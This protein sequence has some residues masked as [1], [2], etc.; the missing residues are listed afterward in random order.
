MSNGIT[1]RDF[2]DGVACSVIAGSGLLPRAGRAGTEVD[3]PPGVTG[4]R[5]SR[6]ADLAVGHALR[7]GA[8]FNIDD[9]P[10]SEEVDFVV[11][12]AGIGGL[13]SAYFLRKARPAASVLILDNH[14]EFGGHARRNEFQVDG[15]LLIGYGGSESI[16]S[17]KSYWSPTA[18][19]LL[20]D[21]G[22]RLDRFEKAIDTP[23]YP[24]LG[25]STGV[26]FPRET[27]GKDTLVTGDPQ[28]SLPTDIPAELHHG[29]PIAQFAANCPLSDTARQDLVRLHTDTSDVMPGMD[30]S[31][32]IDTLYSISYTEF[33]ER[34][35]NMD[36][37][38]VHL[39]NFRPID[40][41][42][43]PGRLVPALYMAGSGYP[44]FQG[45]GLPASKDLAA[46][47]EPYIYHFPDGNASIARLLVRR[48][49]PRV[50]PG[51]SMEDIVTAKFDYA[52]LDRKRSPV[53]LRL[54]STVV[55]LRNAKGGAD[56]LYSRTGAVRRIRCKKAIYAGFYAMMPYLCPDV[57]APQRSA[58][59]QGV[60]SPLVYITVA[61][62]NW[63][64]W[65][66][67]GVHLINNPTGFYSIAK[68]D[69][70]V[71]LG[72]YRFAK[73]PDEPILIH[74]SNTPHAPQPLADRRAEVRA[75]RQVLYTRPFSEFETA[76][77]DEL[78]RML[79]S[80]GF[81]ADRDIAAITINR[82]GHGYAYD[83]NPLTDPDAPE[84][85]PTVAR[86]AIGNIS[87]SG[88]DAAWTAY[89]H[90]AIDEAHRAAT[91]VLT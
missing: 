87:V 56:V 55:Q 66:N 28:R 25:L 12:G 6:D 61:V 8:K 39:F 11:V 35:W 18:L 15:R 16:Q 71:S 3:Y 41:Y 68:L 78:T 63:R 65:M 81:N 34:N 42:A 44:G 84:N 26:F 64:P 88:S 24:G 62:R 5:G 33:L 79:G 23:L 22:V 30:V 46:E 10:I 49:M 67:R 47:L 21:L 1:R 14:D 40:L 53:R 7:D 32:K 31:A 76:L 45:L 36:P 13:S 50:A 74:L 82:W 38:V 80:G 70:P 75:A 91:E 85:L 72:K 43:L 77:R 4:M 69:Y 37:A 60:R 54:N 29:R 58:L 9:Y 59:A 51:T 73:T 83:I 90:A 52:Q 2:I 17:P 27:Y 48:L 57:P 86:A 89:A 19:G 20:A